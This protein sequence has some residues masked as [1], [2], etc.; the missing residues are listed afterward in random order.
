[1]IGKIAGVLLDYVWA[2]AVEL[3]H[4]LRPNPPKRWLEGTRAPV[5][6]LP[7]VYET[8]Q[9]L[10]L[11]GHRLHRRGHPV[12]VVAGLRHNSSPIAP[13]ADIVWNYLVEHD[14]RH[15]LVVAHSKGG[16]IGKH[17]MVVQEAT[18]GRRIDRMLAVATPFSGSPWADFAPISSL[19]AFRRHDRVVSMLAADARSNARILSV[20]PKLDQFLPKGSEL[21]GAENVRL[22]VVGHFRVLVAPTLL[23][24]VDRWASAPTAEEAVS[25]GADAAAEGGQVA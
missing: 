19:R 2:G 10:A 16:L 15:V 12:H 22:D 25:R 3:R 24:A 23:E 11:V 9:F 21:E 6:L 5:I 20:Y 17:L 4:V 14:L 8:W 18:G 1:M 13:S 7:G